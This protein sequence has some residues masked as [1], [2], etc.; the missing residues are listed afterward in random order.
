M[1]KK[2]KIVVV[3]VISPCYVS[4]NR[5]LRHLLYWIGQLH[6]LKSSAGM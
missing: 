4:C 3:A 1:N 2:I 5:K 6:K